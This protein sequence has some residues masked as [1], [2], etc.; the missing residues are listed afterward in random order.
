MWRE[1]LRRALVR[2]GLIDE[3]DFTTKFVD[4]HPAP[5]EIPDGV[6]VIVVAAN[7]PKWA[8]FRC[9]GGCGHRF[10]LSLHPTRRPRWT[11]S[12]DWLNRATVSPSVLQ[13]TACGA[14]F[15]VRNGQVEWCPDSGSH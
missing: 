12:G 1:Y 15:W 3:P 5:A 10:Q 13:T 4:R 8:C 9:P 11:V 2:V 14:H 6:I 7:H